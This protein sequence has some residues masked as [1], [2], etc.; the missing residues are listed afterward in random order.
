MEKE[1]QH[2]NPQGGS[3]SSSL[4][5]AEQQEDCPQKPLAAGQLS[6]ETR[7]ILNTPTRTAGCAGLRE[8]ALEVSNICKLPLTSPAAEGPLPGEASLGDSTS[9][10]LA[11]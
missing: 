5:Q 11:T 1:K 2:G 9:M 8:A 6:F 3:L 4:L 7:R 10:T